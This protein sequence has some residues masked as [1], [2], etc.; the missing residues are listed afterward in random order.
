MTEQ[1]S[2]RVLAVLEKAADGSVSYVVLAAIRRGGKQQLIHRWDSAQEPYPPA[3]D[4]VI[5]ATMS[6][7]SNG[8]NRWVL[9]AHSPNGSA[10]IMQA[11]FDAPRNEDDAE[12]INHLGVTVRQLGSE[13]VN[14]TRGFGDQQQALMAEITKILGANL[15][16]TKEYTAMVRAL[17]DREVRQHE[18]ALT[19]ERK[20]ASKDKEHE[21][22]IFALSK[23]LETEQ[24]HGGFWGQIASAIL[25]DPDRLGQLVESGCTSLVDVLQ[26]VRD[27]KEILLGERQA[28]KAAAALP[29]AGAPK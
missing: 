13:L 12:E 2:T 14:I 10:I 3:M 1:Q 6:N 17:M 8:I 22:A 19:H 20:V 21:L 4:D 18:V 16:V 11:L 7:R 26:L 24:E 9:K 5:L 28:P 29:T 15:E 27:G 25:E 23:E